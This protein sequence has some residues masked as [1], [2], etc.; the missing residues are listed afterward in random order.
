[1]VG[2]QAGVARLYNLERAKFLRGQVRRI[3]GRALDFGAEIGYFGLT[4]IGQ[5]DIGHTET[6]QPGD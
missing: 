2:T 1:M 3:A 5:I 6:G 4:S